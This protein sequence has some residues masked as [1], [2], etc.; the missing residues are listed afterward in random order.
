MEKMC[1]RRRQIFAKISRNCIELFR[2]P[3]LPA[4]HYHHAH[5]S[6]CATLQKWWTMRGCG[7]RRD[8]RC[9]PLG[10]LCDYTA[11]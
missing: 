1:R 10:T 4:P 11:V 7:G 9:R 5:Q 8:R 6:W 3:S 2:N